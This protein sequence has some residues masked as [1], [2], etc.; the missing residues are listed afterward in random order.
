MRLTARPRKLLMAS[1]SLAVLAACLG[2]GATD[3]RSAE[4]ELRTSDGT[5]GVETLLEGGFTYFR[6][7]DVAR[8]VTGVRHYNP[9]TGKVT[10]V[11]G[12]HRISMTPGS[13]FAALDRSV[14]NMSGPLLYREGRFWVPAGFLTRVLATALNATIEWIPAEGRVSAV[15]LG[16]VISSVTIDDREEEGT[17]VSLALSGPADFDASSASAESVEVFI[18]GATLVDSLE[19]P[20]AAGHVLRLTAN[21]TDRGVRA[22]V[23]VD[24]SAGAYDAEFLT[25]PPRVEIRVGKPTAASPPSPELRGVRRLRPD[26]GV[27]LDWTDGGIETVMIDPSGGGRVAG[28]TGPEGTAAKDVTLSLARAL[29][30]ALQREG[31][32][33][34]M[35]RSSD[36]FV[37]AKRRAEIANLAEADVFVSLDCDAWYSGWARGFKVSYYDPPASVGAG[38]GGGRGQGL[39]R[40]QT[41]PSERAVGDLLWGRAQEDY[42]AESRALARAVHSRM[43]HDLPLDDRGVGRLTLG[44]LSGCAMPAIRV[45]LGFISNADEELLLSDERFLRDAARAIA[46]GVVEYR[47]GAEGRAQ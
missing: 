3:A 22:V 29:A 47:S 32:Y 17:I 35:T 37:P 34:F 28:S 5:T 44:V 40:E 36:A 16:P 14:E 30:T 10:L 23:G 43:E 39:P 24:A 9:V 31:F 25:N 38:D 7:E 27:D 46:Q 45:E 26:R 21:Q 41:A 2:P 20:Y 18:A 6:L 1:V 4:I 13:R 33:V 11:V 42:L 19:I 12:A 8:A 15:P